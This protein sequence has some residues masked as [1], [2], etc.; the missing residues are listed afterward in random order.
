M[1]DTLPSAAQWT[2]G[3]Y[4]L[5]AI[6]TDRAG[7]TS[8]ASQWLNVAP[9]DDVAPN[10]SI[11]FP[12]PD[13][14]LYALPEIRGTAS[15]NASGVA[16]VGVYLRRT[17]AGAGG[18]A[19]YQYWNGN[20]WSSSFG[21]ACILPST[22]EISWKRNQNLPAG[23]NLPPG[24]Y[25][26]FGHATDRYRNDSAMVAQDFRIVPILPVVVDAQIRASLDGA[27]GAWLGQS[28]VNLDATGQTVQRAISGGATQITEV[29]VTLHGGDSSKT[30][31]LRASDWAD[32]AASDW[33]ARFFDETGADIT[34]AITSA[35]GATLTMSD[36]DERT[37]R[38]ETSAPASVA[39]GITRSLTLRASANA[40]SETPAVDVVK[41][42]WNAVKISQPDAMIRATPTEDATADY[43]GN[44][45]YNA[46][47]ANQSAQI[48]SIPG[49]PVSFDV[50]LQND[51]N[52]ATPFAVKLPAAPA[53]WSVQL[54][55]AL[56]NGA[57]ISA[58][59]QSADGWSTP[60]MAPGEQRELRLVM[61]PTLN[62]VTSA[63]VTLRVASGTLFD[64]VVASAPLQSVAKIQWSRDGHNWNDCGQTPFSVEKYEVIGFRAIGSNPD[65]AWDDL[66]DF[67]PTWNSQGETHWGETI[68]IH[69][70]T[71]GNTSVAAQCGNSKN[72]DV[73]VT[74]AP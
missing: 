68:W 49:A 3:R 13:Q 56:T 64:S 46:D 69:F 51:G 74:D 55:D 12:A 33:S 58:A 50:Q 10:V 45:L 15:D 62:T 30:V 26:V 9:R 47:G 35:N 71:V 37:I 6:A 63:S 72:V 65:I 22:S 28:L 1:N 70:P 38:I 44:D 67:N 24:S 41:A 39:A 42:T 57:D 73:E 16:S 17:V 7:N 54:F 29:K 11:S 31:N 2:T 19:S 27:S 25:T 20:T 48:L 23:A 14:A 61:T 4:T 5:Q 43:I 60:T 32:F 21:S 8:V 66:P 52:S 34:A 53:G 59:A 36:G 18:A 40:T